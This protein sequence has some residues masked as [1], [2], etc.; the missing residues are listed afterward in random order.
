MAGGDLTHRLAMRTRDEIGQMADALDA[1]AEQLSEMIGHVRRGATEVASAAAQVASTS[2]QGSRNGEAAARSIAQLVTAAQELS[3]TVQEVASRAEAQATSAVGSAEAVTGGQQVVARSADGMARIST[4]IA[5]SAS[6][7]DLLGTRALAIGRITGLIKDIAAQTNL[8]ALNAAIE[9]AR[10][11]D[12]GRGFEVVAEE[13][14]RLAE[15]SAASTVEIEQAVRAMQEESNAAV[16]Q[17]RATGETLSEAIGLG[18]EIQEVLRGIDQAVAEVTRLSQEIGTA[19]REQAAGAKHVASVAEHMREL[20]D[21]NAAAVEE[22]S[23]SAIELA[24]S[25]R[26]LQAA[27]SRFRLDHDDAGLGATPGRLPGY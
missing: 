12:Q 3:A 23:A 5:G 6:R 18:R 25:A 10:A 11:G 13:V 9:A 4:V 2:E 8:L 7:I 14:R 24:T 17:M 27:V 22:L 26:G 1:C 19:T 16:S 15:Q 20:T 21:E